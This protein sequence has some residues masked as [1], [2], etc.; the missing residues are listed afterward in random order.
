MVNKA[1]G[2]IGPSRP[3]ETLMI[4]MK[5]SFYLLSILSVFVLVACAGTYRPIPEFQAQP[6]ES[7]GYARR[8]DHLIFILDTSSSMEDGHQEHRKFDIGRSVVRNFNS[9]M[10]QMNLDVALHTFGHATA[11]SSQPAD[12]MLPFQDYSRAALASAL[13]EVS[14]P[15]GTSPLAS[16]IKRAGID[17]KEVEGPVAMVVV[18]D[19]KDMGA[20]P[21]TAARAL[22][23]DLGN[24][25]CLYSVVVGDA[26][27]E[28]SLLND[29]AAVTDCGT[30]VS[31]DGL[32]SATA[33]N[34]FVQQ[35]LFTAKKDSDGDGVADDS[36]RCSN[37]VTGVKVDSRGCPVDSDNDGVQDS[38]DN[39]PQ[40]PAGTKVDVKG[41]ALPTATQ[42][43]EV[44]AA[45]TWIYKDIQ[46]ENN[47][48]DLRQSSFDTLNE[49]TAA[50]KAQKG[51]KIE[52]Q[53]HTD[54]SGTRS[55][56]MGLSKR[57]AAA[58]KTYLESQNIEASRLTTR[59]FGPDRPIASNAT[60]EGRSRNRRVEIKPI[61]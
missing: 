33:M 43:A 51:L 57:R 22:R 20:A 32:G 31:A 25:L 46:F 59:G 26:A 56:N 10:P 14:E 29:L 41:C 42:S 48:A 7:G 47:R 16:S 40:T 50:L 49:I 44:T 13:E 45:G 37:T 2:K 53:G 19:G 30:S 24:R 18:S 3:K 39:C 12:I 1:D 61:R 55:Y 9:T 23:D 52:I 21:L 17:L 15:G 27:D 28:R 5:S 54:S 11:V 38:K 36:D 8:V 58:V 34:R 60:K 4:K 6:I 35:V